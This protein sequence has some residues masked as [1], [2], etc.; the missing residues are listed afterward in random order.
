MFGPQ[1]LGLFTKAAQLLSLPTEQ[2]NEPLAT[3]SIPALSRLAGAPERYRQAYLRIMEKVIMLTMPAIALM[4]ATSDWVVRIILGPQWTASAKLVVFMGVAALFQP[5]MSTAGWLLVS[6]GRVRDMLRWSLINAPISIL[7]VLVGMPWGVFGVAASWALSRILVANPLL[8]WF[9]GRKGPVRTVDFYRLL[10]PFTAASMVS[11][12]ACF[13]FRRFVVINNPLIGI[14][15]CGVVVGLTTLLVLA[16]LPA[17]RKALADIK[18]S[19]LL[20]RPDKASV[21]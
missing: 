15:A 11:F 10:A 2:I 5:V 12:V 20:L 4:M 18:N 6:Q 21:A 3:V 9:V 16:L 8:F 13:G 1:P 7:A 17:G 19:I 14:V